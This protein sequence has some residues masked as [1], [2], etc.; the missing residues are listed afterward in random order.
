ME[1]SKMI[2]KEPCTCPNGTSICVKN[3]FFNIPA[4]RKFLKSNSVETKHIIDEF[5]RVALIH[6][7]IGFS[8]FH[9]EQEIYHLD[10]ATFRQRIASVFG[11]NYN[12]RLVPIQEQT[13]I[14]NI[15]GFIGKPEF[16]IKN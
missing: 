9:N 1:G 12:E 4:R 2:T 11:K 7:E 13:D 6:P 3:I 16:A 10:K 15:D 14:V 8:M 5:H